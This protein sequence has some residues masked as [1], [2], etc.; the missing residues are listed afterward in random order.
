M[1][2]HSTEGIACNTGEEQ[3]Q[4]RSKRRTIVHGFWPESENFDF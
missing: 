1:F 3:A 4:F 2:S